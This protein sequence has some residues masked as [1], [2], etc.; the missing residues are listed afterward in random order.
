LLQRVDG[1]LELRQPGDEAGICLVIDDVRR[2]LRQGSKLAIAR[3]CGVRP[4]LRVLDGMAGLGLDGIA[5][6]TLGCDVVMIE[7]DPMLFALLEDAVVRARAELP[8]S[9]EIECRNDD[10]WDVIEAGAVY[11]TIYLDPMFPARDK[12]ALPR[13]SAQVL[14]D[15]L[16]ENSDD[17]LGLI[18]R[19]KPV[20]RGRVVVKRRRHDPVLAAPDWQILGR[21]VRFDIYRGS[22]SSSAWCA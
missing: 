8:L 2:R 1:R 9:G 13:K 12:H 3:A 15:L 4:R 10:T 20:A 22:V 19:S 17:L 14:A 6:A 18:A 5:L 11:D 7:R 16:G 21:S